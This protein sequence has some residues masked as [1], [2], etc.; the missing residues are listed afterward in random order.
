MIGDVVI[1]VG[2]TLIEL[3][4]EER[5]WHEVGV[6]KQKP[7]TRSRGVVVTRYQGQ[8]G[9]SCGHAALP[10]TQSQKNSR[11]MLSHPALHGLCSH[12]LDRVKH[13]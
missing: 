12:S 2:G 13:G 7:R 10:R 1:V 9:V 4:W 3:Q 5:S 8:E 11:R 6:N